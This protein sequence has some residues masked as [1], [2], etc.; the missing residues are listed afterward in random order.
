MLLVP[1]FSFATGAAPKAPG[2]DAARAG[3][4][5]S[6]ETAMPGITK[7]KNQSVNKIISKAIEVIL[8]FVGIIFMLLIIAG[9]LKWMTAGGD[10]NK[11]AEARKLMTNA[12]IGLALVMASYALTIFIIDTLIK[13]VSK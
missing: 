2:V 4:N 12:T 3:L 11:V 9:G 10:T 13:S 5:T 7:S 8:S 1:S 6:A